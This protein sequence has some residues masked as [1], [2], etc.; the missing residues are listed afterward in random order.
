MAR[1]SLEELLL[2]FKDFLRQKGLELWGKDHASAHAIR[3]LA[4][5]KDK[6]YKTYKTYVEQSPPEVA[7]NALICLIH[8]TDYLL[9]QQ[10]RALEK[11][12][13]RGGLHREAVLGT[14]ESAQ[15]RRKGPI[16]HIRLITK[17]KT[18]FSSQRCSTMLTVQGSAR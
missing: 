4:R 8:Q 16:R 6:S 17:K 11:E 12:F 1:A 3:K 7:A 9:D 13:L 14:I 18:L 10:L 2:N 15:N 5:V